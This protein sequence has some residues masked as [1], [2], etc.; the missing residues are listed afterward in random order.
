MIPPAGPP[1][2]HAPVERR[3]RRRLGAGLWTAAALFALG[4]VGSD[5]V[6]LDGEDEADDGRLSYRVH[7]L[8]FDPGTHSV[9]HDIND[10]GLVVGTVAGRPARWELDADLRASGPF[11]LELARGG[12]P[13]PG[14]ALGVNARRQV[15][16]SLSGDTV[17]PF[18]WTEA[19]G[20][21]PLPLPP[22]A[23]AGVARDVNDAGQVVGSTSADPAFADAAAGRLVLWTVD[24]AGTVVEVADLGVLDGTG[25]SGHA[26]ND[27]GQ[28]AGTV[29]Y[30]GGASRSSFV[31]DP[32]ADLEKLPLEAE[33]L[34]LN[35]LGAVVGSHEGRAAVWRNGSVDALAPA[36]S[37]ARALNDSGLIVG[38]ANLGGRAGARDG[39]VTVGAGLELLETLSLVEYAR[40]RAVNAVGVIVGDL[41]TEGPDVSEAAFWVPR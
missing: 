24:E 5:V 10:A 2:K 40:A 23:V 26:I 15:V 17:R 29:W 7:G 14:Q 1:A 39:F 20:L 11:E 30:D 6:R 12:E 9:A 28:I 19:D 32:V 13:G 34:G 37:V 16:G 4:C 8:V 22:G 33:V 25:A 38:E 21:R 18:L 41:Y 36:E 35:N 27:S 3:P 31:R